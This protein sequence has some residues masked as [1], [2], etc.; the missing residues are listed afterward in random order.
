MTPRRI[1]GLILI[2]IGVVVLLSGGVFWK[3]KEKILDAGPVEV[4]RERHR[5]VSIPPLVSG[6]CIVAGIVL[7]VLPA[8]TRS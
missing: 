3:Q 8:R 7:L 4:T 1:A 2:I 5:G 6:V